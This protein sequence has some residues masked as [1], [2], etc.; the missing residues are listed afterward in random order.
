M[1]FKNPLIED[2]SGSIGDL[3]VANGNGG[4][5]MKFKP[6]P[7]NPKSDR[8]KAIRQFLSEANVAWKQMLP[9][10]RADWGVWGKTLIKFD[11]LKNKIVVNGW[12]AFSGA[13]VLAKQAG[14]SVDTI[15][16]RAPAIDGY[17]TSKGCA[18]FYSSDV[19]GFV[20]S[21]NA[22]EIE[23]YSFYWG[24]SLRSTINVNKSGY[25]YADTQQLSLTQSGSLL[26]S[27]T[28]NSNNFI[29]IVKVD[30]SGRHSEVTDEVVYIPPTVE[31]LSDMTKSLEALGSSDKADKAD[32][33]KKG[34]KAA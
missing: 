9:A 7:K 4:L 29:R 10:V 3:T 11:R 8:Q 5:Y 1:K 18:I 16:S 28:P 27:A 12:S 24:G 20:I 15:I 25:Q 19:G 21:G 34:D 6:Q 17:S 32:K 2:A 26:V 30:V 33:G 31:Q 14:I 23:R 22:T 13:Y